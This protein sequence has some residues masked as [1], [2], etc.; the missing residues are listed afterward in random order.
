MKE[1]TEFT[2][3]HGKHSMPAQANPSC[4]DLV[5][6]FHLEPENWHSQ[7]LIDARIAEDW[8]PT[9]LADMVRWLLYTAHGDLSWELE[10]E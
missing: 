2:F 4:Y 5:V 8:G 3:W 7:I 9:Y 10:H 6:L 1:I